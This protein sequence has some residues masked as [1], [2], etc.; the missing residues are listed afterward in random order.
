M[1]LGSNEQ[2]C[3]NGFLAE[4]SS[5]DR[6]LLSVFHEIHC[7]Q[8]NIGTFI[9]KDFNHAGTSPN[10]TIQSFNHA[11]RWDFSRIQH[12]ECI[13]G[14]RILQSVFK[15]LNRFRKAF[16]AGVDHIIFAFANLIIRYPYHA[17]LWPC[18]TTC[19]HLNK[20]QIN[21]KFHTV[22]RIKKGRFRASSVVACMTPPPRKNGLFNAV[23][24]PVQA[25][26]NRW[27]PPCAWEVSQI[28]IPAE[29]G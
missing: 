23:Y 24:R 25:S 19:L 7:H 4:I 6:P 26:T 10:F 21:A 11:G 28:A 15:A 17:L 20:H 12:W 3:H 22:W 2:S 14:Q 1:K 16:G 8:A 5:G 13:E 9:R 27:T 18:K 29:I